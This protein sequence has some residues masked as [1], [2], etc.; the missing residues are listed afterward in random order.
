M[1]GGTTTTTKR[2][3]TRA[4]RGITAQFLIALL[5][6]LGVFVAMPTA[7]TSAAGTWQ[8]FT[9]YTVDPEA[10]RVDI[11]VEVSGDFER[12][13]SGGYELLVPDGA[14][15]LAVGGI[16]DTV[17]SQAFDGDFDL[18]TVTFDD[19]FIIRDGRADFWVSY[20]LWDGTSP[21]GWATIINEA[22]ASF[23]VFDGVGA[24]D[25]TFT[26]VMP[27][28]FG[29]DTG[30]GD[31]MDREETGGTVRFEAA[32][33]TGQ[34]VN[35]FSS[36]HV[37]RFATTI[38]DIGGGN[39]VAVRAWPTDPEWGQ[40]VAALVEQAVPV[41][42]ELVGLEWMVGSELVIQQSQAPYLVGYGGWYD[43]ETKVIEIGETWDAHLLLHEVSHTWFHNQM[44]D[45]RWITEG[46]ADTYATLTLEALDE[47]LASRPTPELLELGQLVPLSE[48]SQPRWQPGIDEYWAYEASW[49]VML[50]VYDEAGSAAMTEALDTA[51]DGVVAYRPN[52]DD[53]EAL[54][55]PG[56]NNRDWQYFYDLVDNAAHDHRPSADISPLLLQYV[57]PVDEGTEWSETFAARE[58]ARDRYFALDQADGDWSTPLGVR[59]YM[60]AWEFGSARDL[61][62]DAHG[63][64]LDVDTAVT[65][66]AERGIPLPSDLEETYE[67]AELG[68]GSV[69]NAITSAE[70]AIDDA[71][72]G[73][74]L[75]DAPRGFTTGIGLM[76]GNEVDSLR[77]PL[78]AAAA[79]GDAAETDRLREEIGSGLREAESDGMIRLMI[80]VMLVALPVPVV[81]IARRM[82]DDEPDLMPAGYTP[83]PQ[84]DTGLPD[85]VQRSSAA[86]RSPDEVPA[87][88][89]V[90][91][92]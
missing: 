29:P 87:D 5:F 40:E 69:S 68:M 46:L 23:L 21:D 91:N 39:T 34:F 90:T 55:E 59:L 64:L 47:E 77:E 75:L 41:L 70:L 78:L 20:S 53:R 88:H 49:A 43:P 81:L 2:R 84:F 85:L 56:R 4:R 1:A 11:V 27:A 67:G 17:A 48:W 33:R 6:G 38:V 80:A 25:A 54:I 51:L 65:H 26:V 79:A 60:G 28:G 72:R 73:E 57:V 45:E 22:V 30:P 9:T 12:Q 82:E 50:G 24:D 61:I 58:A 16:G 19:T 31:K 71:A 62:S 63:T 32:S 13:N 8:S 76:W 52:E 44:F 15:D 7:P 74:E 35:Y 10:G 36:S 66:F 37:D 3:A 14:T 92:R 86:G 83:S 89:S 42:S 18:V